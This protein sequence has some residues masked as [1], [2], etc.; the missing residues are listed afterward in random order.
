M[1]SNNQADAT[2]VQAA[3]SGMRGEIERK[4]GRFNTQE[5]AA[6][7]DTADLVSKVQVKYQLDKAQAQKD[8]DEFAKGR[9][10]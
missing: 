10:L 7:K 9:Q 8:V 3:N 6:L 1:T 2:T 5:I 4:W